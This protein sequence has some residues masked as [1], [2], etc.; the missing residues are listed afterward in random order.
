VKL[1]KEQMKSYQNILLRA[2]NIAKKIGE[3]PTQF[4]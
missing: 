3:L 1:K 4:E 2:D